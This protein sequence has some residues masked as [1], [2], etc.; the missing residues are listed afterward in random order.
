MHGRIHMLSTVLVKVVVL[1]KVANY[2]PA[3][4]TGKPKVFFRLPMSQNN[5]KTKI[6]LCVRTARFFLTVLLLALCAH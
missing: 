1:V 6:M 4:S 5:G 2:V 3:S